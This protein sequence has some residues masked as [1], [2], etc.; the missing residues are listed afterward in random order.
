MSLALAAPPRLASAQ[1]YAPALRAPRP[2][3]PVAPLPRARVG[4]ADRRPWATP[5]IVGAVAGAVLGGALG[6][7]FAQGA[8]ERPRCSAWRGGLAV[9]AAL[10][11]ATGALI[12]LAVGRAS[13]RDWP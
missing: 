11:A 2:A 13:G 12:G 3:L 9:G 7:G 10:G 6:A 1:R 8:C 5:L 4:V